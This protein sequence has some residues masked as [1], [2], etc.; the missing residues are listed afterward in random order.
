M[1]KIA[2]LASGKGSIFRAMLISDAPVFLLL[3][4]RECDAESI[5]RLHGIPI[6]RIQRQQYD[7]DSA[8][9]AAVAAVLTGHNITIS[10]MSGFMQVLDPYYFASFKGITLNTHP[11]LLPSFPGAHAV[12]DALAHGVKVTGCTIHIANEVLDGGPILDQRPVY[13]RPDDT[14]ETLH[15]R[16]KSVERIAYPELLLKLIAGELEVPEAYRSRLIG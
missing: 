7:N 1:H 8:Y 4:D 16:I 2:V 3:T 15:E 11:S 13:V 5:A 9:S 10:A 12:K 14:V 6:E